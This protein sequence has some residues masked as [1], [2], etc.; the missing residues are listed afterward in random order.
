MPLP[1]CGLL[2]NGLLIIVIFGAN[3]DSHFHIPRTQLQCFLKPL[4]GA[5][6]GLLLVVL[7]TNHVRP[8]G[9]RCLLS[10]QF[11]EHADRLTVLFIARKCESELAPNITII[12]SPFM[13]SPQ[14]GNGIGP[15]ILLYCLGRTFKFACI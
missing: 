2:M 6:P 1:I 9:T 5:G 11:F 13:S 12:R 8:F 4:D 3:S 15:T 7:V 10:C 14:I